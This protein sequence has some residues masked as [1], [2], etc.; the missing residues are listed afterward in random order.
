[1]LAISSGAGA[2]ET[3]VFGGGAFGK[4]PASRGLRPGSRGLG[5]RTVA[6]GDGGG[7]SAVRAESPAGFL[8]G[9]RSLGS[10]SSLG[11]T[12]A[13][14]LTR[15]ASA[16]T[17]GAAGSWTMQQSL[18][19]SGSTLGGLAERAR[20]QA[21]R[22][23]RLTITVETEFD[24]AC[25]VSLDVGQVDGVDLP[26]VISAGRPVNASFVG[27]AEGVSGSLVLEG[28][29]DGI[30]FQVRPGT[31][32]F[33]GE[34]FVFDKSQHRATVGARAV[35]CAG[36]GASEAQVEASPST[37]PL[38]PASVASQ[39][40]AGAAAE[41]RISEGCPA[42]LAVRVRRAHESEVRR[43]EDRSR[44]AQT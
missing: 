27:D 13:L 22:C 39:G 43:L 32:H 42:T 1:M 29:R 33:T 6:W 34:S 25:W 14:G 16:P 18:G 44:E 38:L 35:G 26:L 12:A 28:F 19:G 3:P 4:P 24:I 40:F 8:G 10:S 9:R 17:L 41:L 21:E 7:R 36:A 31:G 11:S 23:A 37:A 15:K 5:A 2:P 30:P 20:M